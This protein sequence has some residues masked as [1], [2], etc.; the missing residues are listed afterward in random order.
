MQTALWSITTYRLAVSLRFLPLEPHSISNNNERNSMKLAFYGPNGFRIEATDVDETAE[1][2]ADLAREIFNNRA[3]K[4]YTWVS[5]NRTTIINTDNII[6]VTIE[7][8][9]TKG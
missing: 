9:A 5:K 6:A 1:K 2:L 7:D 3:D 8:E 4:T